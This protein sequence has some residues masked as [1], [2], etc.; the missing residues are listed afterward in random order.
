[1]LNQESWKYDTS[2]YLNSYN[3]IALIEKYIGCEFEY[4]YLTSK[5][6]RR[7]IGYAE[8]P[9]GDI[10]VIYEQIQIISNQRVMPPMGLDNV[11]RHY[12][13]IIKWDIVDPTKVSTIR[14]T[15][16]NSRWKFLKSNGN[17][18]PLTE[19]QI[20]NRE[21]FLDKLKVGVAED[22]SK[23]MEKYLGK[24]LIYKT[25]KYSNLKGRKFKVFLVGMLYVHSD[26]NKHEYL[27]K[28]VSD[29]KITSMTFGSYYR[30]LDLP[31]K[32]IGED[33]NYWKA[34]GKELVGLA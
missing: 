26:I 7:I 20:K 3:T 30:G 6:I 11:K 9:N 21:F 17:T 24:E 23:F 29:K 34:E 25:D 18:K 10:L 31:A 2:V 8:A 12:N 1:M 33:Y 19:K 15:Y 32:Q 22:P 27:V 14:T 13:S 16:L 4:A 28:F 5:I